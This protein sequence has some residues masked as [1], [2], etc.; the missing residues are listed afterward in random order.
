MDSTSESLDAR[1]EKL[2]TDKNCHGYARQSNG[3]DKVPETN[4]S[5]NRCEYPNYGRGGHARNNTL[6]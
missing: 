1:L 6:A 3:T 2:D 4:S 5:A